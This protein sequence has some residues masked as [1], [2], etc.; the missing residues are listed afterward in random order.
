MDGL[1]AQLVPTLPECL[2]IASTQKV[3]VQLLGFWQQVLTEGARTSCNAHTAITMVPPGLMRLVQAMAMQPLPPPAPSPWLE[4]SPTLMAYCLASTTMWCGGVLE[5]TWQQQMR[6]WAQEAGSL[7]NLSI[8]E[9]SASRE[10]LAVLLGH[11]VG[12]WG[13]QRLTGS[14]SLCRST[15]H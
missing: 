3:V 13:S 10:L 14:N 8:R 1:A 15:T 5:Q 6:R 2:S 11:E 7:R 4:L 12:T 9:G